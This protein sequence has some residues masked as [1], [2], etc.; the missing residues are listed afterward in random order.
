MSVVLTKVD[1]TPVAKPVR[2]LVLYSV[3]ETSYYG[4]SSNRAMAFA[5]VH[6]IAC[7]GKKPPR[8][9]P[10]Q[11]LATNTLEKMLTELQGVAP[12]AYIAPNVLAQSKNIT[13][14]WRPTSTA[15]LSLRCV[16]HMGANY[17]SLDLLKL[18][19]PLP[20]LVFKL[21]KARGALG[22]FALNASERPTPST[23][24]FR[25][26][27]ANV[28]DAGDVCLGTVKHTT[29]YETA[30]HNFIVSE[31]TH[32]VGSVARIK[33]GGPSWRF[34]HRLAKSGRKTFPVDKLAPT[35]R[36]LAGWLKL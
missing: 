5:T 35:N 14:W 18:V 19:V 25:A 4:I 15:T 7:D 28:Y 17:A 30:E 10:A 36:T 3:S 31:F 8:L 6:D 32:D 12:L 27:F 20:A 23:P 34:W 29:D 1:E 33:G 26:P 2:A 22:V 11:P 24:L 9:L 13:V 21:D 16:D